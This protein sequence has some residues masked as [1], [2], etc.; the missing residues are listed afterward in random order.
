MVRLTL[1]G[2]EIELPEEAQEVLK[3]GSLSPFEIETRASQLLEI[4]ERF[5]SVADLYT[6]TIVDIPEMLAQQIR[7]KCVEAGIK[8]QLRQSTTTSRKK[9]S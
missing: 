3:V 7:L 1:R 9:S 4:V 5:C 6:L 8:I 2:E